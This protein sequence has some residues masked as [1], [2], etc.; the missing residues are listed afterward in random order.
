MIQGAGIFPGRFA[1]SAQSETTFTV[2]SAYLVGIEIEFV[3]NPQG[4]VSHIWLEAG[5]KGSR[6]QSARAAR[7]NPGC[8]PMWPPG[9]YEF[10]YTQASLLNA[11]TGAE[12]EFRRLDSSGVR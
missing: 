2:F 12:E 3:K 7:S 4:A 8:S 10:R 5:P 11:G 9:M 1:L 6:R